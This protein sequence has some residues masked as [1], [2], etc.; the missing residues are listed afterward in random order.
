MFELVDEER[1]TDQKI[2]TAALNQMADLCNFCGECSCLDIR[3]AI[4]EHKTEQADINGLP[5]RIRVIENVEQIG[6]IDN[7]FP[8][9]V[10]FVLQNENARRLLQ[11]TVGV[12]EKRQVPLIGSESFLSWYKKRKSLKKTQA[13]KKRKVAYF[14]GCRAQF[15]FPDV[16]KVL[17]TVFE[18]N[19]CEVYYP[20][21]WCC[22]I[23]TF[24]QGDS[25]KTLALAGFNLD[26]LA[27]V[28]DDGYDIITSCPTCGY[29][30]KSIMNTSAGFLSRLAEGDTGKNA[31]HSRQVSEKLL[32]VAMRN[33]D[34]F[35]PLDRKKRQRVA[36]NTHDAGE[37][38]MMLHDKGELNTPFT[39]TQEKI[40]YF[41]PCH[42]REQRIGQPYHALMQLINGDLARTVE[43][44][45]CSGNGCIMD[46]K[47]DYFRYSLKIG[48]RLVTKLRTE[49]LDVRSTDC[50]GC[51]MQF[52]QMTNYKISHP[53]EILEEMYAADKKGL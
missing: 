12:H 14:V 44:D 5:L 15:I 40:N 10:N 34:Y 20:P 32:R 48:G 45:Y 4:L 7:T 22:G 13:A 28:V 9:V 8:K 53:L 18:R 21:Q 17:V 50:L 27:E 30:L 33:R 39:P 41:P 23:P 31:I 38:L 2:T 26:R 42:Q 52:N 16:G 6:K 47:E 24:L 37:Y 35:C 43:E 46:F 51:H 36:E 29:M 19:D 3:V 25:K 1:D 49:T 11:K